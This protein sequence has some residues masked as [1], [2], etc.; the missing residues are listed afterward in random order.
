MEGRARGVSPGYY[1]PTSIVEPPHH[2]HF[3]QQKEKLVTLR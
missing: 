3:L 2:D 1:T